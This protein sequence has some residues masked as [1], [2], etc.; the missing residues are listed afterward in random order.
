MVVD[1]STPGSV[2]IGFSGVIFG[3]FGG[4]ASIVLRNGNERG[5]AMIGRMLLPNI[6]ISLMPGVSWQGHLGGFVGGFVVGLMLP[7]RQ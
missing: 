7:D 3:V 5:L 4:F 2:T 6:I 1:L